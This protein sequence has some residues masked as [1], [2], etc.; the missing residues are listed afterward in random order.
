[1]RPKVCLGGAGAFKRRFAQL[2]DIFKGNVS[3]LNRNFAHVRL[4]NFPDAPNT[5]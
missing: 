5:T 4:L 2:S 3:D 1:M